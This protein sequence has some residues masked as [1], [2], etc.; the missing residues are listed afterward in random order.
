MNVDEVLAE[1]HRY[2]SPERKRKVARLGIP[3]EN[4]IGVAL[5]DIRRI[6]KQLGRSLSLIHI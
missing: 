4:S 2:A 6:A 5:P 3:E 1:L